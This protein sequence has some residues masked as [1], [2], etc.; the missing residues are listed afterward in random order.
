MNWR[1][2]GGIPLPLAVQHRAQKP[3]HNKP[4]S[5][6][7]P[8]P[9]AAADGVAYLHWTSRSRNLPSNVRTTTMAS[10]RGIKPLRLP[11]L[12]LPVCVWRKHNVMAKRAAANHSAE[13]VAVIFS[14]QSARAQLRSG[15]SAP[16][17]K[18]LVCARRTH[19][20]TFTALVSHVRVVSNALS[21]NSPDSNMVYS[22]IMR[23][24]KG[25]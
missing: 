18:T 12:R 21:C 4:A 13:R 15:R 5:P 9:E 10:A 8:K 25:L 1:E 14:S 11:S 17:V 3:P 20:A 19:H 16:C 24:F 23:Y 22:I 6:T 2:D 7:N